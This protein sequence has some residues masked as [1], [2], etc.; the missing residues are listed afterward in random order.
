MMR[1]PVV[2]QRTI[3]TRL[4]G[5]LRMK[6]IQYPLS[7]LRLVGTKIVESGHCHVVPSSLPPFS[8]PQPVFSAPP[9]ALSMGFTT[10]AAPAAPLQEAPRVSCPPPQPAPA[11]VSAPSG[12]FASSSVPPVPPQQPATASAPIPETSAP[13]AS[14]A[15]EVRRGFRRP[16]PVEIKSIEKTLQESRSHRNSR[17]HG[18]VAAAASSGRV[19]RQR[20]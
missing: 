19:G 1:Y 10:F 18:S 8:A 13:A 9:A 14:G 4:V 16:Q 12:G 2:L 17:P 15:A 20:R 11:P 6:G 5:G 3:L 7:G